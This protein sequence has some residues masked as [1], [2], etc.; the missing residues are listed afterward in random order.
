MITKEKFMKRLNDPNSQPLSLKQFG[1][2]YTYL[3]SLQNDDFLYYSAERIRP[4]PTGNGETYKPQWK[5]A[6]RR[7][8][9]G[10]YPGKYALTELLVC[11]KCD[12]AYRRAV[13]SKN[14]KK[15]AVWRCIS[16]MEYSKKYCSVS[17]TL[18]ENAVR[19]AVVDAIQEVGNDDGSQAALKN[20]QL[21]M[22]MFYGAVDENSIAN[23]EMRLE[24]LKSMVMEME[25]KG[26]ITS[27]AR[28]LLPCQKK[29]LKSK[30]SLQK[31]KSDR[32]RP[33]RINP[34]RA[35]CW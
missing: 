26:K 6:E 16:R 35:K 1:S 3:K 21:H 33:V 20:L 22:R 8:E 2:C 13:W 9:L 27:Q 10:K 23:D 14:G 5:K 7:N 34:D 17:P 24:Q 11:G 15:K 31:R 25:G 28:I 12:T 4:R 29:L 19:R 18:E 32:S 30:R